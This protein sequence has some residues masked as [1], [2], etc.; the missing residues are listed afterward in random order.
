[1]QIYLKF[2]MALIRDRYFDLTFG[3][4]NSLF[5]VC[6]YAFPLIDR[7]TKIK[8][9]LSTLTDYEPKGELLFAADGNFSKWDKKKLALMWTCGM[10]AR[11]IKLVPAD[12]YVGLN[13][14]GEIF[15]EIKRII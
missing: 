6:E 13:R 2:M 9:A 11:C 7:D 3:K 8:E 5:S 15:T 1:M 12:G 10:S 4:F 14:L